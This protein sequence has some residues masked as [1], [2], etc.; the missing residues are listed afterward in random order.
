MFVKSA[1]IFVLLSHFKTKKIESVYLHKQTFVLIV[2]RGMLRP[3]YFAFEIMLEF[4]LQTT[5]FVKS[6]ALS[7]R[8]TS[9][10]IAIMIALRRAILMKADPVV[11]LHAH[12]LF[13]GRARSCKKDPCCGF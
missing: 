12:R 1:V 2:A 5:L 6:R 7:P 8:L 11:S 3:V 9:K 4:F 13:S 10:I